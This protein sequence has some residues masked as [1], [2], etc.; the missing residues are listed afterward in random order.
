MKARIEAA[1]WWASTLGVPALLVL[2]TILITNS[3]TYS[4][5]MGR[6]GAQIE[7]QNQ[8]IDLKMREQLAQLESTR[9]VLDRIH[10]KLD[11]GSEKL[12]RIAVQLQ[13][14]ETDPLQAMTD[15]GLPVRDD[16]TAAWIAGTIVLFPRDAV[17]QGELEKA[18]YLKRSITPYLD[19]WIK[20]GDDLSIPVQQ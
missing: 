19:G 7:A 1:S 8:F 2:T 9:Q 15:A 12:D 16:V 5:A 3:Y 14:L 10:G 13:T 20:M 18:G 6:I 4:E 11:E 17:A